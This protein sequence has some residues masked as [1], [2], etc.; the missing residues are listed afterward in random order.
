M[1]TTLTLSEILNPLLVA[2]VIGLFTAYIRMNSKLAVLSSQN[3]TSQQALK[4]QQDSFNTAIKELNEV[5]IANTEKV[6]HAFKSINDKESKIVVSE[7]KIKTLEESLNNHMRM[8]RGD[9]KNLQDVLKEMS[10][11]IVKLN[12]TMESIQC[13]ISTNKG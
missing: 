9:S 4:A 3:E 10:N 1:D 8:Y 11:S 12:T 13:L 5:I 6:N 2:G 7:T